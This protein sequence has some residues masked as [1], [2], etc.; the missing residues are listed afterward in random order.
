MPGFGFRVT[1]D[2]EDRGG[3]HTRHTDRHTRRPALPHRF[4][5]RR[6]QRR[7]SR[8]VPVS[9]HR[10]A[11]STPATVDSLRTA[12]P[13]RG[14]RRC[15]RNH[16]WPSPLEAAR[17]HHHHRGPQPAETRTDTDDFTALA[18]RCRGH[19]HRR[20][21]R[22]ADRRPSTPTAR[23]PLRGPPASASY[24]LTPD[25]QVFAVRSTASGGPRSGQLRRSPRQAAFRLA[26][27]VPPYPG[28]VGVSEAARCRLRSASTVNPIA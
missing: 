2:D 13:L 18:A 22:Y 5:R 19:G 17:R 28:G 6:G 4:P 26:S 27:G 8:V 7:R 21:Q 25:L 23:W 9:L 16:A 3:R 11:V 24:K 15:A 20:E 14:T 10:R 1:D 12:V